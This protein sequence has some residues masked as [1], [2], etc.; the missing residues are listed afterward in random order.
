MTLESKPEVRAS[1]LPL[2]MTCAN[3][4]LN[5]DKLTVVDQ[6]NEAAIAGTHVHALAEAFVKT[7]TYD[8]EA[9]RSRV[10]EDDFKRI[11][12]LFSNFIAVWKNASKAMKNPQ[13]ELGLRAE[14]ERLVLTGHIDLVEIGPDKAFVLDYK[15][16]RQHDDHYEQVAGYAFL[17][18]DHAGRKDDYHVSASVVYLEDLSVHAYEFTDVTL[19][20]WADK[21]DEQAD[22]PRYVV[23]RKCAGCHLSG[24]CPAHLA[25]VRG[26]IQALTDK[27]LPKAITWDKMKPEERGRL[28][29]RYYVI[30][31]LI[32]RAKDGLRDSVREKGRLDIG[33]NKEM[34][35]VSDTTRFLDTRRALPVLTKHLPEGIV[36][37]HMKLSLDGLLSAASDEAPKGGKVKARDKLEA[38][39]NAKRAIITYTGQPKMWRKPVDEA[40]LE[41]TNGNTT[42]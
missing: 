3:A 2:F 30:E 4:V 34:R 35:M 27:P 12:K 19:K 40:Q 17:V 25:Y 7:G 37:K 31:R 5:P 26:A 42:I 6:D 16:G 22:N 29:D 8:L 38:A 11:G 18:W 9:L 32:A 13:T 1:S 14:T 36:Q 10:S 41:N 21:L 39:L 23:G 28:I 24:S 20:E 15:T 33:G